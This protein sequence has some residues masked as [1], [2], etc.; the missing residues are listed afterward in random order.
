MSDSSFRNLY[1]AA[2]CIALGLLLAALWVN[3][4]L[5]FQDY[6]EWLF[7]SRILHQIVAHGENDSNRYELQ[8]F[9]I[10]PNILVSL[11][12]A[13]LQFVVPV[14]VAGKIVLTL[15]AL[16][17]VFG[18][19]FLM[20]RQQTFHPLRWL[21][22]PLAFNYFFAMGF[23]SYCLGIGLLM[24]AVGWLFSG[25]TPYSPGKIMMLG[26]WALVLF[27]THGVAIAIFLMA[28]MMFLFTNTIYTRAQKLGV[29]AACLPAIVL[30]LLYFGFGGKSGSVALYDSITHQ[31]ISSRYAV[32]LFPRLIPL[33]P[34]LPV[35]YLNAAALVVILGVVILTW[36]A[37]VS[38]RTP[39]RLL[40]WFLA[41]VVV[42]LPV[43]RIG[44]FFPPNPRFLWPAVAFLA[45][46]FA[47][48][49]RARRREATIV[50]FGVVVAG[51]HFAQLSFFNAEATRIAETIQPYVQN[52]RLPLVAARGY[53][54][55]FDKSP[56]QR[57][58]GGV[59]TM[60]HFQR[61]VQLEKPPAY[62]RTFDIG[63]VH[64]RPAPP[65][66]VYRLDNDLEAQHLDEALGVLRDQLSSVMASVDCFVVI[67]TDL[68]LDQFESALLPVY[69]LAKREKHVLVMM[70]SPG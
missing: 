24:F 51:L 52:S 42:L 58:S 56:S 54:E 41:A 69:Q 40:A 2:V 55:E 29:L 57:F 7:Q 32:C 3:E 4:Y 9:P 49:G 33:E 10:H 1:A 19:W 15:I 59:R 28:A 68:V 43:E 5:P 6:P 34:L 16:L 27:F 13:G 60:M 30:L 53:V 11:L 45:A 37:S 70:R 35:S 17:F 46:S 36:R 20:N 18:W 65:P 48:T 21:G 63:L 8:L 44:E 39:Y 61:Y 47:T 31:L 25:M 22:L 62:V 66:E 50:A 38:T 14:K 26:L 12:L 23:L 64:A 67:G